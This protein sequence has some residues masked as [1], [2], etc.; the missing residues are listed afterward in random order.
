MEVRLQVCERGFQRPAF[1]GACSHLLG[2]HLAR[3]MRQDVDKRRPVSGRFVQLATQATKDR[4]VAVRLH[5][6]HALLSDLTRGRTTRRAQGSYN[7]KREPLMFASHAEGAARV[8]RT[9]QGAG[10]DM[11]VFNP[12]VTGFNGVQ[13]GPEPRAFLR[14]A[15]CARQDIGDHTPG[16]CIDHQ[17][18]AGQGTPRGVTQFF[19]AMRTGFEAVAIDAF[20]PIAR[21]PRDAF[22]VQ[23]RDARGERARAVAHQ[24]SRGLR[25]SAMECVR[26]RDERGAHSVVGRLGSRAHRGLST[27]DALVH[28]IIDAGEQEVSGLWLLR[29][30]RIPQIEAIGAQHALE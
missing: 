3:H 1:A 24:R 12:E 13:D 18:C 22:P 25:L 4:L 2:R 5:H 29:G 23:V 8:D 19:Q 26:D 11:A 28:Q 9:E 6:P 17:R 21:Q 27:K 16:R 30:A 7:R 20:D 10:T 15:L 14:M